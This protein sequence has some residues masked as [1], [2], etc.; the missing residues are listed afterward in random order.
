MYA[1]DTTLNSTL[2]VFGDTVNEIQLAIMI[3]LQKISK[4]LDLNKLCLNITKSKFMLFHMPQR[5]TPQLHLN[6]KGSPIENVNEFNFLGLTLDCNLNFKPHTKIIAAKISRVIGVLHKL[7]YIFPAYLLRMIYNSLILPHLNYSLLAWG[8]QYPN[9]ELLQKKAVRVVNFKSPVAHTE[10]ILKGMNQL[11]LPDMYTCQLLKLYYKLY[12]NKLPAY[13][14]NFLPE[15]GDSQHNLRNN[16]I[17][18]PAIRCEFGKLNAKYQ[19]HFRLR[20]L[21]NPSNPPLYPNINIDNDVTTRSLTGFS[22]HI[23][24]KFLSGYPLHCDIGECYACNNS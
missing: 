5:I 3:D 11:K 23:K 9:I 13:F 8:I 1:D 14:E 4:W 21:A 20:E 12:R 16:C 22:K 6:I 24:S 17:R 2:D 7:K 18:L 10:P 19:M 15:Y